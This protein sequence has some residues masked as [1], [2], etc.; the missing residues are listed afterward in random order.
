MPFGDYTPT[1]TQLITLSEADDEEDLAAAT[2]NV[3]LEQLADAIAYLQDRL[4]TYSASGSGAGIIET[5][6]AP[7]NTGSFVYVSSTIVVLDVASCVAGDLLRMTFA[8]NIQMVLTQGNVR[9]M[10]LVVIEDYGGAGTIRTPVGKIGVVG[11]DN[12]LFGGVSIIN[13]HTIITPGSARIMAQA[14]VFD[15]TGEGIEVRY[16]WNLGATRIR[17]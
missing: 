15:N 2:T 16:S 11:N 4:S 6:S 9:E 7:A 10:R 17:P 8:T 13:S 14:G 12:D 1:P 5:Y 3:S